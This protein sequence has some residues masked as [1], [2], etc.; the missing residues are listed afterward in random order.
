VTPVDRVSLTASTAPG[1]LDGASAPTPDE[2]R[3]LAEQF[4]SLLLGQMLRQMRTSLFDDDADT[5]FAD[6]P[7]S[8]AVFSELSLALSRAGGIGIGDQLVGSLLRQAEAATPSDGEAS[9]DAELPGSISSEYGWRRDPI[10]GR[11]RFHHGIDIAMPEGHEVSS[12]RGG[13]VTFAGELPGYGLTVVVEHG[14]RVAT[15]YAHL[16]EL[17]VALGQ[18]VS[19][20]DVIAK[21]GSSGRATG[22]HLHFEVLEDGR[23]VDPASIKGS[24]APADYLRREWNQ[25]RTGWRTP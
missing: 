9:I 25:T 17:N 18:E 14:D 8:D 15:R 5:G 13:R 4:E 6:G 20:G 7:L 24:P 22:P 3:R 16:S 23:P 1:R 10:D 19:A 2:V 21:S 12:V 11:E